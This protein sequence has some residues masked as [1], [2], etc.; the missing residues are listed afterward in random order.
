MET[1]TSYLYCLTLTYSEGLQLSSP[2][3]HQEVIQNR[4]RNWI[5]AGSAGGIAQH[6]L[7]R[8]GRKRSY[9]NLE[10]TIA[11]SVVVS[12]QT[13]CL[14]AIGCIRKV[15]SWRYLLFIS[16]PYS[17]IDSLQSQASSKIY[18]LNLTTIKL[19][20]GRQKLSKYN[21]TLFP[22]VLMNLISIHPPGLRDRAQNFHWPTSQAMRSNLMMLL[23]VASLTTLLVLFCLSPTPGLIAAIEWFTCCYGM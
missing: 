12:V 9:C 8:G 7:L 17:S 5:L 22:S 23:F 20:V 14:Y 21:T 16:Y 18:N 11:E 4:K 1:I 10:W 13:C 19:S 2:H 3:L 6:S 15:L